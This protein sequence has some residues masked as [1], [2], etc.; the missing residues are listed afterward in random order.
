[1]CDHKDKFMF[2]EDDDNDSEDSFSKDS[3]PEDS[4]S[5]DSYSKDSDS[6]DSDSEDSEPDEDLVNEYYN[7]NA[8]PAQKLDMSD[9]KDEFLCDED[10]D[11]DS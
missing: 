9:N 4:D 6:E 5:E 10:N 2:D 8:A 11:D 1:M 7:S 3:D